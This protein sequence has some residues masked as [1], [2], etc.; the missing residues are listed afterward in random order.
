MDTQDKVY[1]LKVSGLSENFFRVL[2]EFKI[3]KFSKSALLGGRGLVFLRESKETHIKEVVDG[4]VVFENSGR[5]ITLHRDGSYEVKHKFGSYRVE[6][7]N[8]TGH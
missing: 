8:H 3:Q 4:L 6:P 1:K 5:T 7:K 2:E